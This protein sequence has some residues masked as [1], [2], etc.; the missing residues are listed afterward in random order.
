V[1]KLG[2]VDIY[3]VS[4]HGSLTSNSM[5]FLNGIAPRV[6]IMDNGETKGGAPASWD[7]VKRSPKLEDL[8]QLHFSK[9]GG[10]EHN[11]SE[12]FIANLSGTDL[13]NYLKLSAWP[14]GH[15]EVFNSR[16]QA[17]KPYPASR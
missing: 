8:W 6:A 5:L 2:A 3:V 17:T 14:D 12:P 1:N 4:H 16:T 15:F 9:E 13:G 11:A 10:V 7:A